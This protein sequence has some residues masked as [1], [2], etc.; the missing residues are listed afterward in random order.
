MGGLVRRVFLHSGGIEP[1]TVRA[2]TG[3]RKRSE[4]RVETTSPI[5]RPGRAPN[6]ATCLRCAPDKRIIVKS[7]AVLKQHKQPPLNT[8]LPVPNDAPGARARRKAKAAQAR[9]AACK[10]QRP[11][12]LAK[13]GAKA[14]PGKAALRRA[15]STTD[16][17]KQVLAHDQQKAEGSKRQKP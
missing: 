4:W 16:P 12:T 8:R 13:K 2:G 9:I 14:A 10:C 7:E 15:A 1:T 11:A 17:Y 3:G 6:P 5:R